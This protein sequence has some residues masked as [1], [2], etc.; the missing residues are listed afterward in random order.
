M[1]PPSNESNFL[2]PSPW[3]R[4]W[5][6]DQYRRNILRLANKTSKKAPSSRS[7]KGGEVNSS[8]K[9]NLEP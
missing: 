7:A 4:G 6:E 3:E 5:G 8:I 1:T 9:C 2:S